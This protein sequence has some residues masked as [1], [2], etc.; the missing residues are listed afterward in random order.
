MS[1]H[2][3][4]TV[5]PHPITP[6]DGR[7]QLLQTPATKETLGV[8]LGRAAPG[9]DLRSVAISV[10]G[11]WLSDS[12][13][14]QQI[15][16]CGDNVVVRSVPEGGQGSDPLRTV[17]TI[18]VLAAM[19]YYVPG[20]LFGSKFAAGIL[21]GAATVGGMLLVD[22]LR[23]VRLTDLSD[24]TQEGARASPTYSISQGRN[25]IRPYQ[26][27]PL[28]IGKHRVK[29]DY[30]GKPF[31]EYTR[32]G[33]KQILYQ[34]FNFG[35]GT[36]A[37]SDFKI[38]DTPAEEYGVSIASGDIAISLGDGRL[39]GFPG[40]VDTE[41]I[42]A[43]LD[44]NVTV[45]RV[46]AANA[47]RLGVDL[48]GNV[49]GIGNSGIISAQAKL[50][51]EYRLQGSTP[52]LSL[53]T[54]DTEEIV[55]GYWSAGQY[56]LIWTPLNREDLGAG[57]SHYENRWIQ[58]DYGTVNPNEHVT[59][60]SY[61]SDGN[62]W[63]YIPYS[64]A[65]TNDLAKPALV[66]PTAVNN[67]VLIINNASTEPVRRTVALD[68]AEGRYEIQVTL[69]SEASEQQT[70]SMQ[71]SAL[72]TYQPDKNYYHGQTRIGVRIEA[73]GQLNGVID[74]FSAVV[75][76]LITIDGS[77]IPSSNPGELFLWFAR[78]STN[79]GPRE[80]GARLPDSRI[81]SDAINAWAAWCIEHNLSC[82]FVLDQAQSV[83]DVLDSIASTGRA[84]PT[85][86]SGK[87]G[88]VWR[89]E[90]D[91]PVQMFG[92]P[93]IRAGTFNVSYVNPQLP[94]VMVGVYSNATNDYKLDEIRVSIPGGDVALSEHRVELKGIT[95]EY[96][97][98]RDINLI[99][100][101]QTYMRR[102]VTFETDIEGF[103]CQRGDVISL[104]HDLTQWGASG[105]LLSG[106]TT[107][108]VV[109]ENVY[110]FQLGQFYWIAIRTPKGEIHHTQLIQPQG[111]TDDITLALPLSEVPD[112]D[113][114]RDYI[115]FLDPYTT[116]GKSLRITDLEMIGERHIRITATDEDANFYAQEDNLALPPP[117]NEYTGLV[118]A[119]MDVLF[120]ERLL[121]SQGNTELT[122]TATLRNCSGYRLVVTNLDRNTAENNGIS[123]G[124]TWRGTF[125]TRDRLQ[126]E[127]WPWSIA[128]LQFPRKYSINY[129]VS[130]LASPPP[131]PISF[132]V[133]T[134]PDGTRKYRGAVAILP[135]DSA[136]WLIG[137]VS[138][139]N[140]NNGPWA[141]LRDQPFGLPEESAFPPSGDWTFA[142]WHVDSTGNR[143]VNPR[144]I[145]AALGDSPAEIGANRWDWHDELQFRG[146]KVGC[147]VDALTGDLLPD[148]YL[149][150][151]GIEDIRVVQDIRGLP[152]SEFT[153]ISEIQDAG[154]PITGEI[155]TQLVAD[156]Q[157]VNQQIRVGATAQQ[158]SNANWQNITGQTVTA[159]FIQHQFTISTL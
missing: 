98:I 42:N 122:I 48:L 80:F 103:V 159:R 88:V 30:S 108:H 157:I 22:E 69:L 71:W 81:D 86:A 43:S 75:E 158:C 100:A 33:E 95:N 94:G 131:D 24:S 29:P 137:Y 21:R 60:E 32:D 124:P 152:V 135:Q 47:I 73:D 20:T 74:E 99:A 77:P 3:S 72:R 58:V 27:M 78:G 154:E 144:I 76:Q 61:D 8:F 28:V 6:I 52:W 84:S 111:P 116:P 114:P 12:E 92:M 17:L 113:T 25:T 141:Y 118:P 133:S 129:E 65:V 143:S 126:F 148:S 59:N 62:R 105:R 39:P 31:T 35:L 64:E 18:A 5:C 96:Q 104:S 150:I 34:T 142:L 82:N 112:N 134:L 89:D 70:L 85:W 46:S 36:L 14:E 1:D 54:G 102:R 53:V 13:V 83:W 40:N 44:S 156:G 110:P 79:I 23:P 151:L 67:G 9:L 38:G 97:A 117:T 37:F 10:N 66:N 123:Y 7:Y 93:N 19:S 11:A 153:Y 45:L 50:K 56:R 132:A 120:T 146:E 107:T 125:K 41:S 130:G 16:R 90:D 87:L 101:A 149:D 4:I 109:L 15:I 26:P 138:G 63:R 155:F 136:G 145:N 147:Y 121:D 106:D 57:L 91:Q 2:V 140:N 51:I 115:W 55:N 119:V 68:V 139:H 49:Y 128:Q 127:L